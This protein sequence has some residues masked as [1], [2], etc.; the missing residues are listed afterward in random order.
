MNKEDRLP[1]ALLGVRQWNYDPGIDRLTSL[2]MPGIWEPGVDMVARGCTPNGATVDEVLVKASRDHDAPGEDCKCGLY[3]HYLPDRHTLRH[4]ESFD[5]VVA[6]WGDPI[7]MASR[8]F[9]SKYMRIMALLSDPLSNR[10]ERESIEGIAEL[11]GVPVISVEEIVLFAL[12][13]NLYMQ[14]PWEDE[15]EGI[16]TDG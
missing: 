13:E 1:S 3:A 8:G 16:D 7:E 11:Y 6:G 2:W 9:R 15:E 4:P 5:G 12:A 14:T 10:G